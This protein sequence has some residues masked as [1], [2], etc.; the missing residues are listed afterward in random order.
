[1]KQVNITTALNNPMAIATGALIKAKVITG[2]TADKIAKGTK[3]GI[4][5]NLTKKQ[6]V[7]L[8]EADQIKSYDLDLS[9]KTKSELCD[10][11]KRAIVLGFDLG[12]QA[13]LAKETKV[14][15]DLEKG[16]KR[17]LQQMIGSEFAYYRRAL[18]ERE[19]I[20]IEGKSTE[21]TSAEG[22]YFKDLL[23]AL[24]RLGKLESASFKI[25]EHKA[26]IKK[27][28]ESDIGA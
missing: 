11:I 16:T 13:L 10:S 7:D 9:D 2:E 28:L 21:K 23:S 27:L 22:M 12:A 4:E 15:T 1:M 19:R 26:S 20:A 14:L 24:D 17:A 5:A 25:T 18:K 8:M 6:A 3:K